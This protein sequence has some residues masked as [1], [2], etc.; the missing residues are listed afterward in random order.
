MP[1]SAKIIAII[2]ESCANPVE[3][4]VGFAV[5]LKFGVFDGLGVLVAFT[6]TTSVGVGV[7]ETVTDVGSG[8]AVGGLKLHASDFFAELA[9]HVVSTAST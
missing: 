3:G 8:V 7:F 5:M 1:T 2:N 9:P 6:I 4:S